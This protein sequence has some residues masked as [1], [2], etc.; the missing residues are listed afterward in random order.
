MF[1]TQMYFSSKRKTEK[2]NL[3]FNLSYKYRQAH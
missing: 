2:N 3:S 1:Y